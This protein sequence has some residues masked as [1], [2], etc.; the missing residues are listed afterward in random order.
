MFNL[1]VYNTLNNYYNL[2]KS[3]GYLKYREVSLIFIMVDFI[4]IVNNPNFVDVF[5]DYPEYI[6]II[7]N[8]LSSLEYSSVVIDLDSVS[9]INVPIM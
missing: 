7:N 6:T 2:L 5:T 9:D 3:N 1:S 4:D 8:A